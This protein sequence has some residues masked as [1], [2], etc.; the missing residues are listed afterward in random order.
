MSCNKRLRVWFVQNTTLTECVFFNFDILGHVLIYSVCNPIEIVLI[1]SL[2]CKTIYNQFKTKKSKYTIKK[3]IGYQFGSVFNSIYFNFGNCNNGYNLINIM[4]NKLILCF[5]NQLFVKNHKQFFKT[6]SF[7]NNL[8]LGLSLCRTNFIIL[9][10]FMNRYKIHNQIINLLKFCYHYESNFNFFLN[11]S[12]D[13]CFEQEFRIKLFRNLFT[14]NNSNF[15]FD[16]D[17]FE[18]FVKC[19]EEIFSNTKSTAVFMYLDIHVLIV[20][21]YLGHYL[22]NKGALMDKLLVKR[23]QIKIPKIYLT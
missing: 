3:I 22:D 11:K 21:F 2:L 6:K 1:Y 19:N 16:C 9:L 18:Y 23:L 5:N 20:T 12:I 15:Q 14:I 4:Y 8:V 17:K 7:F 10:K 13:Y